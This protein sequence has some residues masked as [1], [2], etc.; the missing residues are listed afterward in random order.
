MVLD[1]ERSVTIKKVEVEEWK[2][3]TE[4]KIW[5][6]ERE[7]TGDLIFQPRIKI[8]DFG[9]EVRLFLGAFYSDSPSVQLSSH[10]NGWDGTPSNINPYVAEGSRALF[11]YSFLFRPGAALFM[12]GEEFDASY[13]P[14]PTLSP[15]LFGESAPG[16]GTWLYGSWIDWSQLKKARHK[17]MLTDV[18][19]MIA[20]RK[21]AA[22]LLAP[23]S[24]ESSE[25]KLAA[26]PFHANIIVPKPYMRWN[27]NSAVVVLANRSTT[28]DAHITLDIPLEKLGSAKGARY[29]VTDLWN[30]GKTR[31][32]SAAQLSAYAVSV[33]RDKVAGGGLGLIKI[34][35]ID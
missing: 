16:K 9:G 17:S 8:E 28:A 33:K 7:Y 18:K 35:K 3:G 23:G 32:Y 14:L 20:L 15:A 5:T 11:G 1:K 10:D 34:E 25:S 4:K 27:D 31:T 12:S 29:R 13:R 2:P 26:V 19:R 22:A 30:G 24:R 21:Q 6:S